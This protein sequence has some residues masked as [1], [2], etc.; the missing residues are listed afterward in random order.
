MKTCL[1]KYVLGLW[2]NLGGRAL[3]AIWSKFKLLKNVGVKTYT[4]LYNTGVT[5]VLDYGSGI[6]GHSKHNHSEIIQNKAIRYFLGV[7]SFTPVPAIQGEMGWLTCK[8]R[9]YL[10]MFRLWNR[11]IKMPCDRLPRQ[12]LDYEHNSIFHNWTK[13]MGKLFRKIELS[14]IYLGK[15]SCDLANIKIRLLKLNE[16]DWRSILPNK[17]KLRSYVEYKS[18]Y[19]IEKYV[20]LNNKFERS[21]IAK[22]RCGILKLKIESG[23]FNNTPLG[24]RICELCDTDS[25]EDEK[26]FICLCPHYDEERRILYSLLAGIDPGFN[27]LVDSDHIFCYIMK[28][29]N[30]M[31]ANYLICIW[32]KRTGSL[33]VDR[34]S[35]NM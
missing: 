12:I 25:V 10:N 14:N 15:L 21:M 29:C 31:I 30:R 24:E 7:H 6:W 4:K 1:M 27:D 28:N 17:P 32:N 11:I 22:V 8:Y 34:D 33:Y 23:R 13:E 16:A 3:G 26:H 20:N 9:K 18:E 5:P 35:D 19:E 2:Q